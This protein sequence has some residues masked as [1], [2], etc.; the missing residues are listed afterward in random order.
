MQLGCAG[1]SIIND[2]IWFEGK[3]SDEVLRARYLIGG[4]RADKDVGS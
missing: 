2:E 4:E 1:I 3:G